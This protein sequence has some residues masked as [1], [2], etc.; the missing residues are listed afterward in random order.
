[1]VRRSVTYIHA[2]INIF[3][4]I[5]VM[6]ADNKL[7]HFGDMIEFGVIRGQHHHPGQWRRRPRHVS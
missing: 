3:Y 4:N 1:M 5:L 2:L 6:V 7:Q